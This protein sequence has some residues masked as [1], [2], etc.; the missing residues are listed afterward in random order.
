MTM[1]SKDKMM[2]IALDECMNMIGRDLVLA[3]KDLCCCACG[4]TDTGMFKYNLGMDTQKKNL[5]MGD[6]TPMQYYAF[7]VINPE[8]GKVTRDYKSSIL[9]N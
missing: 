7:V 6:E 1:L 8:T 3:N 2:K 4:T 5:P 9:P